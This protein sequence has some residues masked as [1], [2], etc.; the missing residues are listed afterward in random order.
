MQ[1]FLI[2][3]NLYGLLM[4]SWAKQTIDN[5]KHYVKSRCDLF[6]R[7]VSATMILTVCTRGGY[8][9]PN[10]GRG[11]PHIPQNPYPIPDLKFWFYIPYPRPNQLIDNLPSLSLTKTLPYPR[12]KRYPIKDKNTTLSQTKCQ[13]MIPYPR[14]ESRKTIPYRPAHARIANLG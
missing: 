10:L 6:Q 5:Y 9:H 11:V 12:Q 13:K 4:T 3:F 14:Q 7:P 8:Y 1:S 2:V